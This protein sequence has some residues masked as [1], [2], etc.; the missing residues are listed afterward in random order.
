MD[1]MMQWEIL[2]YRVYL[3]RG[4][5]RG[6]LFTIDMVSDKTSSTVFVSVDRIYCGSYKHNYSG[7]MVDFTIYFSRRKALRF[8]WNPK[9]ERPSS[10]SSISSYGLTWKYLPHTETNA[11]GFRLSTYR[12]HY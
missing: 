9:K 7:F 3:L 11:I 4:M 5:K 12:I 10:L 6:S 8:L 1:F 2:G